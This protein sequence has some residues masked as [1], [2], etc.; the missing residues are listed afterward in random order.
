MQSSRYST[1]LF[2]TRFESAR[3]ASKSPRINASFLARDYPLIC[4]SA[5]IASVIRS[6]QSEK[7]KV[8]GRRVAV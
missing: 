8:T 6:N 2:V 3:S 4:R 1:L 7:T 5:V